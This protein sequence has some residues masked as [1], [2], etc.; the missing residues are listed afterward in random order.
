MKLEVLPAEITLSLPGMIQNLIV[1]AH[2]ADSG[3]Q[4]VSVRPAM[5]SL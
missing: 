3:K 1:L 2:Y 4:A 5:T